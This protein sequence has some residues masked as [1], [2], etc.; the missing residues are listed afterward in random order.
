MQLLQRPLNQEMNKLDNLGSTKRVTKLR[1]NS[2]WGTMLQFSQYT[3]SSI[4]EVVK[5]KEQEAMWI[6]LLEVN[7]HKELK[8]LLL[9]CIA[10]LR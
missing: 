2:I 9:I 5:V 3:E 8:S 4:H 10:Y 1:A 7:I 6:N